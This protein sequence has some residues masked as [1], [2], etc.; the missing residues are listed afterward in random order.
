MLNLINLKFVI[1]AP[2]SQSIL[3][4]NH[5]KYVTLSSTVKDLEVWFDTKTCAKVLSV[6]HELW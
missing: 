6:L 2:K 4:T 3:I 5:S 1:I